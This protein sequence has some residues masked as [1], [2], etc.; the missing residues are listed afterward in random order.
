MYAALL[1]AKLGANPVV[2]SG[3]SM[4]DGW[5]H[6]KELAGKRNH[7]YVDRWACKLIVERGLPIF[8]SET[9]FADATGLPLWSA[10]D[11]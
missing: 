10:L 9:A 6:T 5:S 2:L 8:T 3:F 11:A 4:A 7:Q 1:A